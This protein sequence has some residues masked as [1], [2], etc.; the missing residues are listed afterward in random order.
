MK[1]PDMASM[2]VMYP[3]HTHDSSG[4]IHVESNEI[5]DYTLGEFLD[6]WGMDFSGK[7][8][9][10]TVNGTPVSADTDYRSHVFMDGEQ[11]MLEVESGQVF[12]DPI[13]P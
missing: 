9:K 10:M 12:S 4:T 11:V 13:K 8:V 5:R 6:V 1:M 3:T 2:P 7:T